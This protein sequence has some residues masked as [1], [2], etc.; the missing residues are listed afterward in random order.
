[1]QSQ[2]WD[3][4]E[5]MEDYLEMI[6]YMSD[7]RRPVRVVDLARA[8]RVRP[9]S[10]TRMVQKLDELGLLAYEKYRGAC[11]TPR[12]KKL[13]RFL[14]WRDRVLREFLQLLG[15]TRRLAEQVEAM[16]HALTPETMSRIDALVAFLRDN[17]HWLEPS[18]ERPPHRDHGP[19][20]VTGSD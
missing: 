19:R 12:G 6:Y 15:T 13:G 4:T 18:R 14:L 5:S 1:M 11:L 17:P 7:R 3:L 16:E 8:L 9:S 20:A 10:A 2:E